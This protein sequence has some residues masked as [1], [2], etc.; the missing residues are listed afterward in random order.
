MRI[1]LY[2]R[3]TPKGKKLFQDLDIVCKRLQIDFDPEY[4]KDMNRV[5]SM[6]LMGTTILLVDGE[7]ALIDKYPSQ[8]ELENLIAD[9]MK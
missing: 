4:F 7:P 3:G 5:Y 2:D 1:Q 9:Y 8:K 6:G